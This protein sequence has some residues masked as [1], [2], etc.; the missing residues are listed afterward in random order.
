MFSLVKQSSESFPAAF[1]FKDRL[2]FGV[3]VVSA[4]V[5]AIDTDDGSDVTSAVLQSP[6]ASISGTRAMFIVRGGTSGKTYKITMLATISGVGTPL[7]E[8]LLLITDDI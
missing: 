7:E 8:Q 3:S 6:T 5:S 1:D 4:I 2:P